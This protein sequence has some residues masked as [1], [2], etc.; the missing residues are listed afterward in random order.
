MKKLYVFV[1]LI[2]LFSSFLYSQTPEPD[3]TI[4]PDAITYWV[5]EGTHQAIL[6]VNWCEPEIALAWGFRFATDSILV[7][8]MMSAITIADGRFSYVGGNGI[9]NDIHYD[10]DSLHLAL[11]GN[12]WMYNINGSGAMAG[13]DSQYI[14]DGDLVKWGDESCG[15]ADENWN[16]AW[17][18]PIQPVT[19]PNPEPEIFDGIVGTPDC[20]A[21]F[22]E[23]PAIIGW[24]TT[25]QI[26]RG[27]Q[28]I[29]N[30]GLLA[31]YGTEQNALGAATTATTEV[32]SLGD[33]GVAILTFDQPIVNGNG[34]DFAVFENSLNDIFLELAFVEVS[35]DGVNY[36]RFPATSNTPTD[37][38][39]TN[40]GSID[41]TQID[42][43]AGKYRAG[44]GTPFD[45]D[46]LRDSNN[47]DINN[48]THVKL[49]DVIGTIDPA[50][51]TRDHRGNL[52]N[53]P[54]PTDFAS[55]GFDL[56]GIAILNGWL[57]NH[58]PTFAYETATLTLFPNPCRETVT[59][60]SENG[61]TI[62]L[63]NAQGTLILQTIADNKTVTLNMQNFPAGMYILKNG[64]KVA[65][66]VK[67]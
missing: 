57:P 17:T 41:A 64:N 2:G 38:Q 31:S 11:S 19:D 50:Y 24:A 47:L 6:V 43:L 53:D 15:T 55:G 32:V 21:I 14:T 65:K 44:W 18:T 27:Y 13:F 48:I 23:N 16:Y 62:L 1:V 9:V 7:S 52:V 25:C 39:I 20:Q 36:V 35:S 34:Y 8:D 37:E 51:A 49:I 60:Q 54:Y 5:G 29:V 63:Y 67:R 45:L 46:I 33:G 3:A 12:Y 10:D 4:S 61:E 22:C 26:N 30:S 58:I 28:N 66:F 56:D 59:L 40:S 42:Q